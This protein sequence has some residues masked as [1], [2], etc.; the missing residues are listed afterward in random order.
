[1]LPNNV[2]LRLPGLDTIADV[3]VKRA[4]SARFDPF[5]RIFR[6]RIVGLSRISE[7]RISETRRKILFHGR[8]WHLVQSFVSF[9][10]S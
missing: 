10:A 9:I 1:M 6:T 2:I 8:T 4:I 3:L 5:Q 7:Q